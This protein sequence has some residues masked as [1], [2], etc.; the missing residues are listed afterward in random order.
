LEDIIR[1]MSLTLYFSPVSQPSRAV[2]ALL[3]IGNIKYE[4]KVLDLF[5]GEARTPEYYEL[6]PLGRVPFIIHDKLHLAESNAIL[7]HLV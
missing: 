7:I 3:A 5:K 2:L 1:K 4:G 6:N